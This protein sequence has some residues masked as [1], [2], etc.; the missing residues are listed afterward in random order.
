LRVG[1]VVPHST[2]PVG[3]LMLKLKL[4]SECMNFPIQFTHYYYPDG[5]WCTSTVRKID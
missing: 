1:N 2:L 3:V 5:V 4:N